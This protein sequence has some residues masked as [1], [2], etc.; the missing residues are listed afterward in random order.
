MFLYSLL[1]IVFLLLCVFM[2]F[3]VLLQKGKSSMGL[4]S[5]GG[6]TQLLFGG[7]GGQDIFQKA[8]WIMGTLFMGGSL[9]LAMMNRPTTSRLLGDIAQQ[10]TVPAVPVPAVV[11]PAST[12]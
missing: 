5:L 3:I 8:T 7:S 10:Q 11:P 12:S 1:S 9:V 2:V 6:G 4:G